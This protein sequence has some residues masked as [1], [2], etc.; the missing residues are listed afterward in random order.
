LTVSDRG[1]YRVEVLAQGEHYWT[2]N[3]MEYDTLSAAESAGRDLARRWTL[4]QTWRVVP[5]THTRREL[6]DASDVRFP[7]HEV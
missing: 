5:T 2:T 3:A 1:P 7:V 6:F 4:V